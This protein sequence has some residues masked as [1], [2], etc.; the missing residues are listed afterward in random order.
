MNLPIRHLNTVRQWRWLEKTTFVERV[1]EVD[2]GG[3]MQ[4]GNYKYVWK[5][6]YWMDEKS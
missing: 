4:Y 5:P 1:I 2:I 3:S 6:F